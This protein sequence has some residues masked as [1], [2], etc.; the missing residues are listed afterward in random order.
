MRR[1]GYED[2][3]VPMT[4]STRGDLDSSAEEGGSFQGAPPSL[5]ALIELVRAPGASQ[6]EVNALLFALARPLSAEEPA[7]ERAR[8]LRSLI[9]DERLGKLAGSDGRTVRVAASQALMALGHPFSLAVPV[10]LRPDSDAEHD[11][12]PFVSLLSSGQSLTGLSL[13]VLA[14]MLEVMRPMLHTDKT[15]AL[16]NW[17]LSSVLLS[18]VLP[19]VLVVCGHQWRQRFIYGLGLIWLLLAGSL[20]VVYGLLLLLGVPALGLIVAAVGALVVVGAVLLDRG[21][22]P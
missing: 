13:L 10:E 12:G 3:L 19:S 17:S 2:K 1:P 7:R 18:T 20:A 16:P 5:S 15:R 11:A 4:R 14:C 9:R 8:V 6:A 21:A 22:R